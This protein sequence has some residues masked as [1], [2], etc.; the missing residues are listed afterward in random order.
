MGGVHHPPVVG[1]HHHFIA[2]I[3]GLTLERYGAGALQQLHPALQEIFFEHCGHFGILTRKHL[4]AAHHQGDVG[5]ERREH[6]HEL[7]AGDTRAHDGD[8]VGEHLGRVAIAGGENAVVIGVAPLGNARAGA[9]ADEHRVG[10]DDPNTV[11]SGDLDL[12]RAEEP[13]RTV[14]QVDTLAGEQLGGVVLQTLLDAG[15]AFFERNDVDFRLV[16][17][18]AHAA[19]APS[20]RH[21]PTGGDHGLR[22]DAVP[23]MRRAAHDVAFDERDMRT[24]ACCVRCCGVTSRA[25]TND[26]ESSRHGAEATRH[27][28][29]RQRTSWPERSGFGYARPH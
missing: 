27:R 21:G 20:E 15:D 12:M 3:G 7:H 2:G 24:N 6:V 14:H 23:Q 19:Q 22:R 28:T 25:A 17:F 9:G 10:L 18:E 26:Y 11:D 8:L 16:P 4:L 13:C 29:H 1:A 5:A